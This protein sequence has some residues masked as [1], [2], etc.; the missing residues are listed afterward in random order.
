MGNGTKVYRYRMG[1]DSVPI[2]TPATTTTTGYVTSTGYVNSYSTTYGGNV[3]NIDMECQLLVMVNKGGI[4]SDIK[5][6]NDTLGMW[7]ISRCQEM[8]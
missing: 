7:Q 1:K 4:I 2:Y 5:V 6:E 3:T 8:F